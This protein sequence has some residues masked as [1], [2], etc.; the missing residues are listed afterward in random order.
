[1]ILICPLSTLNP[2]SSPLGLTR[3]SEVVLN[4]PSLRLKLQMYHLSNRLAVPH[5][6]VEN[7]LYSTL[8]LIGYRLTEVLNLVGAP[9]GRVPLRPLREEDCVQLDGVRHLHDSG[10]CG[11][12]ASLFTLTRTYARFAKRHCPTLKI[13]DRPHLDTALEL[14]YDLRNDISPIDLIPRC[15]KLGQAEEHLRSMVLRRRGKRQRSDF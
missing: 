3:C 7:R 1:M 8:Y 5:K 14:L 13:L 10:F 15:I 9:F 6:L 4:S 2:Q 11:F 12:R